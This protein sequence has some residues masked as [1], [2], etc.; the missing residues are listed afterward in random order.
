MYVCMDVCMYVCMY[1]CTMYA[2]A[3]WIYAMHLRVY[4]DVCLQCTIYVR[5]LCVFVHA[6]FVFMRESVHVYMY[7][8]CLF[9]LCTCVY[10]YCCNV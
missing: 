1:V 10:V 4:C 3:V 8:L 2:C 6:M 9:V 5:V 7:T